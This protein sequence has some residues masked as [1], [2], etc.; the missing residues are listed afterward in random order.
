MVLIQD[1]ATSPSN[2]ARPDWSHSVS[3]ILDANKDVR[4]MNVH[5]STLIADGLDSRLGRACCVYVLGLV[6]TAVDGAV[7][8]YADENN[9]A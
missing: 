5:F 1:C 2:A 3:K 7:C 6:R 4:A 8:G 9:T